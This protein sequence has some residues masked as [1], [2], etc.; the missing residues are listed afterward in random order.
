M[1]IKAMFQDL[2]SA[3][4][5]KLAATAQSVARGMRGIIGGLGGSLE[6]LGGTA[7]KVARAVGGVIQGFKSF[8]LVGGG[9]AAATATMDWVI[10][11]CHAAKKA[12]SEAA[13]ALADMMAKSVQ[14]A[15]VK[16]QNEQLERMG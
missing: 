3:G 12:A 15:R 10:Q 7:G 11:K 1:K 16:A 2:A 14:E 13:A 4:I 5:G 8:G 6:S 9:I